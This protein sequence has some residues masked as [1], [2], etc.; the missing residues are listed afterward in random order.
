M[1]LWTLIKIVAG[2][3]VIS[4]GALTCALVWHVKEKPLPLISKVLPQTA[5]NDAGPVDKLP[6]ADG[7]TPEIDPG[8]KVFEKV[9]E[10]LAIGDLAGAREKLNTIVTTY[11]RS[12]AS[13][14]A[15]R[16]VGEM[17]MDDLLSPANMDGKSVH[18]VQK[19]ESFLGISAKNH[20]SI[21]CIMHLNGMLE[22]TGLRPGDELVVMPLDLKVL[23]EPSKKSISLWK[24]S[25]FI[26]EYTLLY[27]DLGGQKTSQQT[28]VANS[29][30][31][32]GDKRVNPSMKGYREATKIIALTKSALQIRSARPGEELAS[33][34]PGSAGKGFVVAAEDAEELSLILRQGNEVEIRIGAP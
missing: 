6:E 33:A 17:N 2:A 27:S 22:L 5:P 30:G 34:A 24:G 11:P 23:I 12:K 15:R 20:T 32:Q 9:K 13:P 28:T 29:Y 4:A 14:E 3:A 8:A 10:S 19:G 26:K 18:V 21:D 7:S 25:D 31:L 1:R 16:I